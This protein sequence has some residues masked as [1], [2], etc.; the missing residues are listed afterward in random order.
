MKAHLIDTHHLVPRSR[1]SAK[2]KVKY[3][4][5]VSQKMGV[6]GSLVFHKHIL[7]PYS[8]TFGPHEPC[9]HCPLYGQFLISVVWKRLNDAC[10]FSAGILTLLQ[11]IGKAYQA[12][13]QYSCHRAV[14]LFEELPPHQYKTGWV[15]CQVGRAHFELQQYHEV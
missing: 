10:L 6:S 2:V 5:H 3:Q 8:F 7:F 11:A 4:G 14:E 13:S 1:S 12:L 15:L 9:H